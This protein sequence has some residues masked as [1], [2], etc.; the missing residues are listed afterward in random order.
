MDRNVTN[1]CKRAYFILGERPNG[2]LGYPHMA[3]LFAEGL[4]AMGWEISSNI[5]A[6]QEEPGG[7][8][9]FPGGGMERANGADLVLIEEDYFELQGN[10]SLPKLPAGAKGAVVYLDRADVGKATGRNNLPSFRTLDLILRCHSL[11]LYK[12]QSNIVPT[13]F[14]ITNR[15]AKACAPR[16]EERNDAAVWNFRHTKFAH[17]SRLWADRVIRPLLASRYKINQIQDTQSVEDTDYDRL[18]Q[19]QTDRKHFPTYF[20]DLRTSI[21]CACFG[22][23]FILPV[24]QTEAS[25]FS[26][27]TRAL[28]RR[29]PMTTS[30]IQQWDSYRLWESFAAGVA[31]LH[32][33]MEK[34]GFMTDGPLPR[35]LEHYVPVDVSNPVKSLQ[36]ILEDR[37]LLLRIGAAGR[38][39]ALANYG[40]EPVVRRA[41]KHLGMNEAR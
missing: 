34:Y 22:G 23:W 4:R 28:I 19:A 15:V 12:R 11:S 3:V 9:L 5:P 17:N 10:D 16:G 36:P 18:M 38:E 25:N 37:N 31:T 39:W 21:I 13:A 35:P 26:L 24:R 7:A 8:F 2:Y 20:R 6:W 32:F 40:P 29:L 14:G 30:A 27:Q 41:L 1:S 33:D